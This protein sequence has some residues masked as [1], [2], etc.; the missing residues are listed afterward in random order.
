MIK[1]ILVRHPATK[2][3]G[4]RRYLGRTD[5]ALSQKGERQAEIISDYLRNENISAI[6]SSSL[7]RAY[8]T[9]SIIAK[10]QFLKPI[11]NFKGGG[12]AQDKLISNGAKVKRDERLNE[13][14][15]GE[16]EGMTFDQIRKRYPK[17]AQEYLANPLNTQIP[18]AE[19]L[20]KFRNRINKAL[21]KILAREKGAVVI[22]SHAGVNKIII[23]NLLK[24]PLSY[25]WQIKQDIGAINII[26]IHPVRDYKG[27]KKIQDKHISNGVNIISLI[28]HIL[29]EN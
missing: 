2:W 12:E 21:E 3:D 7:R 4:K 27:G 9:A 5:I 26:E 25:F 6:Y 22:V 8:Q 17:L 14:D 24:L 16:W 10:R 20:L 28:N 18:G 19:S 23:C 15:F 1:L 13:I 11:G 29:W